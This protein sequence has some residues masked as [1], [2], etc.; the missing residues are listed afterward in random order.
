MGAPRLRTRRRRT[1]EGAEIRARGTMADVEERTIDGL[2]VRI[3]P[4]AVRRVRRL[5]RRGAGRA[6]PRPRRHRRLHRGG[7]TASGVS[8][9]SPP[10]VL[11]PVDAI[12]VLENGVQIAP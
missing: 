7:P 6:R 5:Q 1:S 4:A 8:A 9:C 3:R 11:A 2:L 10:A 12:T